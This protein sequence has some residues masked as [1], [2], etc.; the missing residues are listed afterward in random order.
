MTVAVV[1]ARCPTCPAAAD[2]QVALGGGA[3]IVVEGSYW[4]STRWCV[5][6]AW[7]YRTLVT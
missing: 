1:P 2:G 4:G 7:S 5:Y 3:G 6:D